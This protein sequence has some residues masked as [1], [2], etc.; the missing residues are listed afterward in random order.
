M[1]YLPAVVGLLLIACGL[2]LAAMG[3]VAKHRAS[4]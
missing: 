1:S 4:R 2:G 3:F